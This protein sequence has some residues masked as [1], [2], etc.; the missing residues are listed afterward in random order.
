MCFLKLN[1]ELFRLFISYIF[2]NWDKILKGDKFKVIL[3]LI[4]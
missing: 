1:I 2:V 3:I 4:L